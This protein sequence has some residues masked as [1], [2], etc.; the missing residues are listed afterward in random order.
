MTVF[1]VLKLTFQ[2]NCFNQFM[3][4][5]SRTIFT[6]LCSIHIAMMERRSFPM[7]EADKNL[8]CIICCRRNVIFRSL[9]INRLYLKAIFVLTII[10]IK[11]KCSMMLSTT[12]ESMYT[13]RDESSFDRAQFKWF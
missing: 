3:Y 4:F 10:C 9:T 1:D 6:T 7:L 8:R 12:I 11:K 2:T 5:S 13:Y